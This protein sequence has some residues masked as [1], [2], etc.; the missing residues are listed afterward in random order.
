[1]AVRD[2]IIDRAV[3]VEHTLH[4]MGDT[5]AQVAVGGPCPTCG[6]RVEAILRCETTTVNCAACGSDFPIAA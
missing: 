3:R 4:A 5:S 1:M 6:A 2:S